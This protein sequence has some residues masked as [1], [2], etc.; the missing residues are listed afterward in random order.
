MARI[1]YCRQPLLRHAIEA[2]DNNAFA[3][4][5]EQHDAFVATVDESF[6]LCGRSEYRRVEG[7]YDFLRIVRRIAFLEEWLEDGSVVFDESLSQKVYAVMPWDRGSE[8]SRAAGISNT[9]RCQR[10]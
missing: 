6:A 3:G 8:F 5:A 7:Y 9:C 10:R 1:P 4:F 2:G